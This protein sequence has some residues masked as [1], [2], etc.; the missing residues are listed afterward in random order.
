MRAREDEDDDENARRESTVRAPI[1]VGGKWTASIAD[2]VVRKGTDRRHPVVIL[3]M[4]THPHPTI[5]VT[6]RVNDTKTASEDTTNGMEI[7]GSARGKEMIAVT[8]ERRGSADTEIIVVDQLRM[9]M[10]NSTE[11]KR[12]HR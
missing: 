6:R 3:P 7:F 9:T 5:I 10:N 2:V 8:T 12:M 11:K 4:A 1:L